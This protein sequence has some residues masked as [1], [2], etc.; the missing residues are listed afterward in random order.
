MALSGQESVAAAKKRAVMNIEELHQ[1]QAEAGLQLLAQLAQE[2]LE[3]LPGVIE[4]YRRSHPAELVSAAVELT[5]L[6]RRGKGKFS[7]AEAMFFTRDGFEMA[8]AE[9][10]ARHTAGRFAGL[11]R[12]LDLCCGIG[13]DALA[14][15]ES[16]REVV[17]VDRDPLVLEMARANARVMS[18]ERVINFVHADVTEFI[19]QGRFLL[20]P[21]DAIFIDP[22]RREK[23]A[24]ARRPEDYSPP[25]SWCLGLTQASPR[26]AIKVSPALNY[27][28]LDIP[29]EVEIISLRGECKEAVLWLGDFRTCARRATVLPGEHTITDDG[30]SSEAIGEIGPWLYEPDNAVV[31][32]HLVQRLAG[33]CDLR[34]IDPDIAYLTGDHEVTS[35]F[36]TGYRV[37]EAILWGLKRLN[38]VL[39]ARNIG[40]V[41]IKKRGFPLTPEELHPKLKLS[42]PAQATL[43]CTRAE[44]RPVVIVADYRAGD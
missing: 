13:G 40:K 2:S 34:R 3:D 24:A 30:P 27:D 43:I 6:R 4:R 42:G 29:A 25:L 23:R 32:A 8:S 26:V 44:G 7:R 5:Q 19:A 15:A 22:S 18:V 10:V 16:A 14:L 41:V 38:A 21:I 36:L 1:L 37:Q 9:P 31:R 17:A 33:E 35:P 28:S 11:S 20:G 39:A 12:V